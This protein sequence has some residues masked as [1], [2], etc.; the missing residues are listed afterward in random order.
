VRQ[1]TDRLLNSLVKAQLF[2]A[3]Y[4]HSGIGMPQDPPQAFR[5][6]LKS[7]EGGFDIG[8]A[9][10]AVMY[11]Q[12]DGV[13]ADPAKAQYGRTRVKQLQEQQRS[14]AADEKTR[15]EVDRQT[16]DRA[17]KREW[18]DAHGMRCQNGDIVPR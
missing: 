4:L 3:C 5:W 16:I 7:A 8:A 15:E 14:K 17:A 18:L 6:T 13:T 10:V 11:Q 12:G 2:L 1:R 9:A